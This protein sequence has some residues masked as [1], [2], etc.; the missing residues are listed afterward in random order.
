MTPQEIIASLGMQPH[1]EGG[2]YV[3]LFRDRPADG[4]RGVCTSIYFLLEAGQSSHWHRVDAVEIWCWHGGGPLALMISEDGKTSET[5][6]LGL[7]L[8]NGERPQCV[9]PAGAWQ[10]ARPL[11]A[12]ALVGCTVAPAFQFEGFEMAP[13]G[14][15]PTL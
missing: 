4:G 2:W 14:W 8:R 6:C 10:A 3:E 11:G 12:W 1:P 15:N 13:P 5:H 7:N 9:V